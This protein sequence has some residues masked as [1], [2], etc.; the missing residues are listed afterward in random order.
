NN[1]LLT[2]DNGAI[3]T[4][5]CPYCKTGKLVIRENSLNG[6][7]FLGCSHYPSCNQTFNNITVLENRLLCPD[8]ESG[9][10]TKRTGQ[11]GSFFGCTN[12][13]KCKH[14]IKLNIL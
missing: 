2:K 7:Q 8:C 5:N 11:F 3:K 12:Y 13:P 10:M 6:N 4:T 9:F 1:Y 14:T